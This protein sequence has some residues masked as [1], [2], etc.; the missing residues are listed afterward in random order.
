MMAQ[1]WSWGLTIIGLSSCYL[2]GSGRKEGW[3]FAT[4]V[5]VPWVTYAIVSRQWGFIV[6]ATIY[7]VLDLRN[8]FKW[9]RSTPVHL[10]SREKHSL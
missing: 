8:F 1:W 3:L 7:G 6:S 10:R 5:N 4:F 2:I 9:K